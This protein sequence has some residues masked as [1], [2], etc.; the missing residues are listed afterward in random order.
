MTTLEKL[1][2]ITAKIMLIASLKPEI[3]DFRSYSGNDFD[4]CLAAYFLASEYYYVYSSDKLKVLKDAQSFL[5]Q[6]LNVEIALNI[7]I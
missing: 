6:T 2:Q 5:V 4:V 7:E 1:D 3:D